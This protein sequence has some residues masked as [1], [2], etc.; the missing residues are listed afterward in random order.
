MMKLNKNKAAIIALMIALTFGSIAFISP[1]PGHPPFKNLKVLPK[2]ITYDSLD[3]LMDYYKVALNVKCGFCHGR[4]EKNPKK[5]DMASDAN[6]IKDIARKMIL[7]TNE[8][9]D[10]YLH[11]I[12]H[13]ATDSSAVQMVT[14]NTCHRGKAKPDAP[15]VK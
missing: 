7:M 15:D 3:H 11:T 5:L 10:K 8:M 14:C 4:S 13:P 1:N 9:N 6:P 2:D 12:N